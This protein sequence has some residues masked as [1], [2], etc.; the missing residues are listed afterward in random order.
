MSYYTNIS[1]DSEYF[2]DLEIQENMDEAP[3]LSQPDLRFTWSTG[4]EA[5]FKLIGYTLQ[6][7]IKEC[8]KSWL[9]LSEKRSALVNFGEEPNENMM[10]QGSAA[11][12]LGGVLCGYEANFQ[13]GT[14]SISSNQSISTIVTFLN[15][16]LERRNPLREH[17]VQIYEDRCFDFQVRP[18][19][20]AKLSDLIIDPEMLEDIVDN[21]IGHLENIK[22]ANGI[23]FHGPPGTGKSLA[24]QALAAQALGHGYAAA[25]VA[26]RVNYEILDSF[27]CKYM[28]PG[29]LILEDIDTFT[30][31]RTESRQHGFSDFLMFMSGLFERGQRVVVIATTNHLSFLDDAVA[32]RPAR[33]NRH[34]KFGLPSE[35]NLQR[36]FERFFPDHVADKKLIQSCHNFGF[37]GSHLAEVQRT[38][39]ILGAKYGRPA[40]EFINQAIEIVRKTFITA[41]RGAGFL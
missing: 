23:I 32:K 1:E 13:N 34:Y 29:L 24:T 12:E 28:T 31:S 21:T 10:M 18:E 30:E 19:P 26:G 22:G 9:V 20:K 3:T 40:S 2:P 39:K 14:H 17:F 35:E 37:A 11:F 7:W 25:Y 38:T 5:E 27:F 36:M 4:I 8:S 16:M 6:S 41:D 15:N 33:F